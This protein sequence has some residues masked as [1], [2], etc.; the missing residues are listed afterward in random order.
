MQFTWDPEKAKSNRAK[1]GISFLTSARVFDDPHAVS[2]VERI[3]YGEVRWQTIGGIVIVLVAHT[4]KEVDEEET[5]RVISA[6]KANRR[7]QDLYFS[8]H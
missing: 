3:V 6:R 4:V 2:Y 1:Q 8:A 5:V 7:E